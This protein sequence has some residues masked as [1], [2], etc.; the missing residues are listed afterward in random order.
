MTLVTRLRSALSDA[1]GEPF[2]ECRDCGTTTEADE[3][4]CPVCGSIEIAR[5]DLK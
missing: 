3:R 2:S 4:A 1:S 5:Y